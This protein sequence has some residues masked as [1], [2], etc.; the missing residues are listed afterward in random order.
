MKSEL[1][2]FLEPEASIFEFE[3]VDVICTSSDDPIDDPLIDVDPTE[4]GNTGTDEED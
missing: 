4:G 1:K 2:K 3:T